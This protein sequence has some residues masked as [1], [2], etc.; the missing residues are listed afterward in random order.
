MMELLVRIAIH[1]SGEGS[2]V[3]DVEDDDDLGYH[4]EFQGLYVVQHR[5]HNRITIE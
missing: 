2:Q 5:R 3:E 1:A 4:E